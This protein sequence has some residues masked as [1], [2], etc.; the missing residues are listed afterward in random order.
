MVTITLHDSD[1]PQTKYTNVYYHCKPE[2]VR[3]R[4]PTCHPKELQI[5][6]VISQ[7][8]PEHKTLLAAFRIDS[9]CKAD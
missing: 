4:K 1:T 6:G 8:K 7:L 3:L 9:Y 2:C 5:E